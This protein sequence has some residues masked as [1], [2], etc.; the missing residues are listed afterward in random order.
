MYESAL[1]DEAEGLPSAATSAQVAA[2]KTI[3][4]LVKP[5]SSKTVR[6]FHR[7][8]FGYGQSLLI[9]VDQG[10]ARGKGIGFVELLQ[11]RDAK[12]TLS[13]AATAE[14][15]LLHI[16]DMVFVRADEEF[17]VLRISRP[18]PTSRTSPRSLVL[19]TF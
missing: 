1:R 13:G 8:R 14:H 16:G 2:A 7:A 15:I 4:A 10:H 11:E 9:A 3:C 19:D 17:T 6:D 18:H 5:P 12:S